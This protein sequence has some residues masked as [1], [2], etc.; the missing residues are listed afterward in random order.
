M[1]F[2]INKKFNFYAIFLALTATES[3]CVLENTQCINRKV[4]NNFILYL[5]STAKQNMT[6]N[7][8]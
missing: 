7:T 2:L 5:R 3:V 1:E 6:S 8:I 4:C